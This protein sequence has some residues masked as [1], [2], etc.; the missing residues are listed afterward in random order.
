[1]ASMLACDT[2]VV[3][4]GSSGAVVAARLSEDPQHRV[5][6]LDAGASF[7]AAETPR[8]IASLNNAPVFGQPGR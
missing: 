2:L 6:L 1:M 8:E 5:L 7:R 4:A 3:G